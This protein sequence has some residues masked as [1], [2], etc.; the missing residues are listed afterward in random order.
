MRPPRTPTA[1]LFLLSAALAPALAQVKTDLGAAAAA[2]TP[3]APAA[4]LSV[5]ALSPAAGLQTAPELSAG[6]AAAPA[7]L[8]AP[9]AVSAP[10]AVLAPAAVPA[11]APL[12]AP[13]AAVAPAALPP[14]ASAAE[15][16][17]SSVPPA[18]PGALDRHDAERVAR[19]RSYIRDIAAGIKLT[20]RQADGILAHYFEEQGIAAG[21]PEADAVRR[22]LLP[23]KMAAEDAAVATLSPALQKHRAAV[24]RL[25]ADHG[26]KPADVEAILAKAGVLGAIAPLDSAAF[27]RQ[28]GRSLNRAALEKAVELY[29]DNAQGGFMR[30]LAGN[31]A[32]P[33]GKSVEEVARDGVFAYVDFNGS[34]VARASSGRDPDVRSVQMVFYVTRRDGVWKIGGYRQNRRTGRTDDELAGALRNW[35]TSGGIP[36][37][38]LR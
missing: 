13:A 31:M 8:L 21:S 2:G 10:A 4:V 26:L 24:L 16:G 12:S 29:P 38:D 9:A 14:S 1:I 18:P 20:E 5:G 32:T 23:R 27:E 37:K 17:A 35:L 7:P 30:T 36:E 11:P 34:Q 6:L 19:A 25:S 3:G 15:P 28:A 22:A 33:S